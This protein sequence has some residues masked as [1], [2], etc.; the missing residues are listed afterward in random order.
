MNL[1]AA[2]LTGPASVLEAPDGGRTFLVRP[3][4][5]R[6]GRA[7]EAKV[8]TVWFRGPHSEYL[9]DSPLGEVLMR[10]PGGPATQPAS[11]SPWALHRSWPLSV[12]VG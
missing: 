11:A 4:W 5:A 1:F 12:G 8:R 7:L 6:L 3:G 9:A 10:E 2:R